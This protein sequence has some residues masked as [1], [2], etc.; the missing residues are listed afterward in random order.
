MDWS[1][2]NEKF[3]TNMFRFVDVLPA[4]NS[5]A[6]V[7]QHLKEYFSE[8]GGELPPV[9]NVGL[10]L[11]SLAPGLMAGA[12][13]KNVTGMAKM[14][15]TG[16]N[17]Q[18][19]LSV[20]K[21][22]RK[23]NMTFT[24][25]ILGEAT[26]SEKEAQDYQN[27]YLEL[28]QSLA[29]DATS[30]ETNPQI[31]EDHEGPIPKV[32]VSVK[33]TALC[34]KINDKAWDVTKS[35]LKERL[36]PIFRLGMEKNV[37]VN[38]DMEHYAVKHLTLE[39]FQ[40]LISEPEFLKHKFFGCVIQAYLKDSF[41]D[42]QT[43][44]QFAKARGTPFT[45]RLVKGAYWDTETVEAEQQGWPV[46]VYTV[47]AASDANFEKC[48]LFLLDNSA[49]VRVALASHNVRTLSSAIVHAEK[50]GLSPRPL[51]FKCCMEWPNQSRSP[52]LK[53]V[54]AFVSMPRLEILSLE[55][56]IS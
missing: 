40:E 27:R 54:I 49:V 51:K 16:E 31:D 7:A 15:I 30:W 26:L 29:R 4:L 21:K 8:K 18:E 20:F 36:R 12:I 55:W 52:W 47:K 6:D 56:P 11:G 48:A 24:V 22:A 41:A 19:A 14:F 23:N 1:M 53:W 13:R 32:N 46:P 33:M 39:V 45:V 43:L 37:F 2:K 34:P 25:D 9:F 44:T 5:G 28:I 35:T 38:L 42:I 17:P 3:K 50:L 10:G